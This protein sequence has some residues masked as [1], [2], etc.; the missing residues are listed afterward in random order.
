MKDFIENTEPDVY[1]EEI[2]EEMVGIED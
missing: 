2:Y 1:K